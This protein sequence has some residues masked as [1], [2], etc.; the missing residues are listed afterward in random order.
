MVILQTSAVVPL[1]YVV[2]VVCLFLTQDVQAP[3]ACLIL[4]YLTKCWWEDRYQKSD[5][6]VGLSMHFTNSYSIY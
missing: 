5:Q 1:L 3:Q 4:S 2:V 6:A